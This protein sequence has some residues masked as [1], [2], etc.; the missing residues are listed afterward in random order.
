M[1]E[2]FL[3]YIAENAGA[4]WLRTIEHLT[5][6]AASLALAVPMGVLL[7]IIA[8]RERFRSIRSPLLYLLGLGQTIPSLAIIA[9]AVGIL[10]IGM[11]PAIVAIVLYCLLPIARN[12]AS[13]L[14]SVSPDVIDAARGM[15]MMGSQILRRIELPLAAP[16][17]MA[18]IRTATV[19][20]VSAAALAYLIGGGGLGD[21]IF[22]GIA[23]FRPEAMLAGAIPVAL[24]ALVAD[25]GLG[26]IER[27]FAVL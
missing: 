13:G 20:A 22:S 21:F 2:S 24:L 11:W 15:G 1:M 3:V 5:I 27:R 26:W 6:V 12:T 14:D 8:S 7:G 17:I 19:F 18:G 16:F 4:I 25:W 23:L 9:L 10:G